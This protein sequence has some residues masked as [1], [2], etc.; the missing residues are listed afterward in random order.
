MNLISHLPLAT[1]KL[2]FLMFVIPLV[3]T[4][5]IFKKILPKSFLWQPGDTNILEGLP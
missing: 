2:F 3:L 4:T 1:S 5:V